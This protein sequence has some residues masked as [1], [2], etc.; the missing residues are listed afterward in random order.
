[1]GEGPYGL[2]RSRRWLDVRVTKSV[3]AT[4]TIE[5]VDDVFA[6]FGVPTMVVTDNGTNFA[7]REFNDYLTRVGV[8]YYKYTAP[9]HPATNGQAE[10]SVQT[11]KNALRAMGTTAR[12]LKQNVNEFLRQYKNAP[13]STTNVPP[14]QLFLERHLRTRLDLVRPEHVST[15]I[16]AK[17]FLKSSPTYRVFDIGDDV[18]FL[19]ND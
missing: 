16:K 11:V 17:Q 9:Y 18:Q 8:K 6:A 14:L 5:L 3:T 13:H 19:P 10:R 7:S 4:A 2:H 15:K 12:T 1:M